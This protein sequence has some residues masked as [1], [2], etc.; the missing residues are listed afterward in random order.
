[1]HDMT[2]DDSPESGMYK[3]TRESIE[4][5]IKEKSEDHSPE[6]GMHKKTS[7]SIEKLIKEKS[8]ARI[9]ALTLCLVSIPIAITIV[10]YLWF[11]LLPDL[12]GWGFDTLSFKNIP[13]FFGVIFLAIFPIYIPLGAIWATFKV[14]SLYAQVETSEVN[15]TIDRE[16]KEQAKAEDELGEEL[17][18]L[19]DK[20]GFVPLLRWTCHSQHPSKCARTADSAIDWDCSL[21]VVPSYV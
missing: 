5:L 13:A 7:E 10:W 19:D 16:S 17:K 8:G 12:W 1:M 4:K 3:K 2:E 18:H 20:S 21:C 15:E 11:K 9:F 14:I 6:S